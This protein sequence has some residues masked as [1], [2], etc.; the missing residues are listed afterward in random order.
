MRKHRKKVF[1]SA[2]AISILLLPILCIFYLKSNGA[3]IRYG[4]IDLHVWDGKELDIGTK[5]I[6]DFLKTK[7]YITITLTGDE[8]TDKTKLRFAE[9]KVETI[10]R[11]KDSVLGVKFH[12][13]KKSQYWAYIKVLDIL[14]VNKAPF[15]VPYKDDIWFTN[16]RER[17]KVLSD[18]K[19]QPLD[20]GTR[21]YVTYINNDKKERFA[22]KDFIMSYYPSIIIY[23]MMIFFAFKKFNYHQGSR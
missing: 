20:C 1:Y 2:G 23:L 5:G 18:L 21:E 8:K 12:F 17:K 7:K 9:Q 19:I 15:Y 22:I 16:S 6:S 10:I 3:F 4:S 13:E 11:T 14:S